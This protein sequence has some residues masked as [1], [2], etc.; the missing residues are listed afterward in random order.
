MNAIIE[1]AAS[2]CARNQ[3]DWDRHLDMAE[4]A[5]N[6]AEHEFTKKSTFELNCFLPLMPTPLDVSAVPT[7]KS[8]C[9][10]H[11]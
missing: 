8:I 3:N 5:V 4:F 9:Q 10:S 6:S 11:L 2:L 7:A 1:D